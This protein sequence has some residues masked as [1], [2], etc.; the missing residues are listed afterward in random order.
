VIADAGHCPNEDQP[1][2]T[3]EVLIGYWAKN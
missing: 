2:A 1:A 3:A